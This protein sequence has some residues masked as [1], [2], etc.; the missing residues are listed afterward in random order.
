MPINLPSRDALRRAFDTAVIELDQ[1]RPGSKLTTDF[2][3]RIGDSVF[4]AAHLALEDSVA[5]TG[6][7][8]STMGPPRLHVV[9]A[10]VGS[11]KTSFSLAFVAA[12]VRVTDAPFGCLVVVNQIEKADDTFRDLNM[13]LPGKVAVWTTT[14]DPECPPEQRKLP[15][16]AATFT[17]DDLQHY[18]VAVITHAFF[19]SKGNHKATEVLQGDRLQP[20]ALTVIDERLEEVTV[21]DVELSAAQKVRETIAA[22]EHLRETA[23]AVQRSL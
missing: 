3:R 19:S 1:S 7:P 15:E 21:F 10:P 23:R 20:R 2:Y 17:K 5:K 9:S 4:E 13:L 18:P 11:G 12:L 16:P 6:D 22:N 14:H 8:K